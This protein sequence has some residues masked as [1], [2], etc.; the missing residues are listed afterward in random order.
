MVIKALWWIPAVVCG[1]FIYWLSDQSQPP[2]G[3]LGPDYVK[4]FLGYGLFALAVAVGMT[5]G[6]HSRLSF[7]KVLGSFLIAGIYGCLDE[8]HQ[9]FVPGRTATVADVLADLLGAFSFLAIAF[10]SQSFAIRRKNS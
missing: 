5:S 8:F 4:H 3:D 2:G 6:F 9:G 1:A 10:L 7:R